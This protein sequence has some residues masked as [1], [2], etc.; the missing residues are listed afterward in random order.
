MRDLTSKRTVLLLAVVSALLAMV[1][2]GRT[3]ITGSLNDGVINA[4]AVHVTG[5][6]AVP[7]YFGIALVAAAGLLAA[8]TAGRIVR[9]PAAIVSLLA[10]LALLVLTLKVMGDPAS[11]VR[12]RMTAVTGHTGEAVAHGSFGGWFWL[13]VFS[14]LLT[15]ATS[16]LGIF[17]VRRWAGLSSRYEAPSRTTTRVESDWDLMSRGVDPTTGSPHG[18]T[19]TVPESPARES[20]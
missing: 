10:S 9:W 1:S 3:W 19:K 4:N 14:A 12:S 13:A 11:A 6:Q 17:G 7:G 18:G 2:A 8:A 20:A 15:T 16:V 5:S